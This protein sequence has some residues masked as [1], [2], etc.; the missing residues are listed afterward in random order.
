[1][2][3]EGICVCFVDQGRA[4]WQSAREVVGMGVREEQ[5]IMVGSVVG[6]F[7]VAGK[8]LGWI[9]SCQSGLV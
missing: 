7:E 2:L 6:Q 1:M 3:E 8:G 5:E 4:Y 9:L